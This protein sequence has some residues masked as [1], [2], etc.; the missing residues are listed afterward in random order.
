MAGFRVTLL[1]GYGDPVDVP[2]TVKD[3]ICLYCAYRY[4]NRTAESGEAPKQF[5][6]LLTP[7][8]MWHP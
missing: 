3:A 6:D 8:R 4:E 1:A 7:D 5:Y 2:D